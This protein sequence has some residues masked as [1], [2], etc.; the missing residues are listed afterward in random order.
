[1]LL[2]IGANT[3]IELKYILYPELQT[4]LFATFNKK[5]LIK[6]QYVLRRKDKSSS[7]QSRSYKPNQRGLILHEKLTTFF[8]L[9]TNIW[10]SKAIFNN[11][12][13]LDMTLTCFSVE[14]LLTY[15]CCSFLPHTVN[16]MLKDSIVDF[17]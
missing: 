7:L 16:N 3:T 14:Y 17:L 9:K 5:Y 13:N 2:Y 8:F 15:I 4:T 10:N 11:E 12:T 1:M 6:I